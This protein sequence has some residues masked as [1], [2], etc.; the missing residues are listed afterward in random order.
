MFGSSSGPRPSYGGNPFL[1]GHLGGGYGVG[2]RY[3]DPGVRYKKAIGHGAND[4]LGVLSAPGSDA[5]D[6]R[7][8]RSLRASARTLA[9][10]KADL[11]AEMSLT[12]TCYGPLER[13]DPAS[14]ANAAR[15]RAWRHQ[16]N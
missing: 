16:A 2:G 13:S 3:T 1:L 9:A 4:L 7:C 15:R 11:D 5:P 10:A 8:S 14:R 12:F 6:G